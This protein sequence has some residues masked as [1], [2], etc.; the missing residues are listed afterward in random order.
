MQKRFSGTF[1]GTGATLVLGIGFKPDWVKLLNLT[2]GAY[3]A[4]LEWHKRMAAGATSKTTGPQEGILTVY[5]SGNSVARTLV[6]SA[7]GIQPYDGGDIIGGITVPSGVTLSATNALAALSL[8]NLWPTGS[9]S[10]DQKA[11]GTNGNVLKWT[12]G[13]AANYTGNLDQPISAT[14]VKIGSQIDIGPDQGPIQ[15][16]T[17]VAITG[18]GDSANNITLDRPAP[19]GKIWRISYPY[20]LAAI[21]AK[22]PVPAGIVIFETTSVNA[23]SQVILVEAG[24]DDAR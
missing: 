21:P 14:Y 13:S 18:T 23:A 5:A 7:A 8:E 12:L 6:A 1:I 22:V 2:A 11:S 10:I 9:L 3:G 24:M 4:T 15:S 17:V 20:D 16:Y 19:S